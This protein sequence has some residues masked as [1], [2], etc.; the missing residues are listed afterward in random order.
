MA[1]VWAATLWGIGAHAS[2]LT[3]P[4]LGCIACFSIG[5]VIPVLYRKTASG[6][7]RP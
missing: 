1:L 3:I 5:C 2:Q 4:I 7:E 6:F